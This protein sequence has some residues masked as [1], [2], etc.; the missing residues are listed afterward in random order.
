ML[1]SQAIHKYLI[2]CEVEKQK[3][4]KT[5]ENY[6]HYLSRLVEFWGDQDVEKFNLDELT[7]YRL[8]LNRLQT[9][10]GELLSPKTQN[11][12]VIALRN[13]FKFLIR[14]GFKVL[15]TDQIELGKQ[16]TRQVSYL[17]AEELER[18]RVAMAKISTK[19]TE[20]RNLLIL[21]FL[22][23][24]GLRISE[25]IK[26]NTT[27]VDLQ[28]GEF[29]VRGKGGKVR[30]VFINEKIVKMVGKYLSSRIDNFSPLFINLRRGRDDE[31]LTSSE[32]RRLTAYSIQELIRK[33]ARIAGIT[34][35]VTPHT[36]RHS[37]ATHLLNHGADLRSVQEL[38][39]HS[40]I[41]TTQIYTHVSNAQ[42]KSVH[43][44][45]FDQQNKS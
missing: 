9:N 23:T 11:F 6:Q 38:L 25:L 40:S 17:T 41:A 4:H 34:K 26:L 24:T 2:H 37:F 45:F 22:Y 1:L 29:V 21:E 36:L 43:Q 8:F 18:L 27:D 15:T 14:R 28:S 20:T 32:K 19:L 31:N 39:G 30:T 5:I 3:S 33:A 42:L 44:A 35:K 7:A 13:L 10:K 16:Q 12:H